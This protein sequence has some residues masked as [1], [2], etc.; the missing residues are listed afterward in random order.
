MKL[1]VGIIFGG[2]SVEHEI[3]VISA[4]QA[5]N[6]LNKEKFDLVP[7]YISKEGKFYTGNELIDLGNYGNLNSLITK[8]EEV[9]FV[10]RNNVTNL[11]PVKKS[12]FNNK[13]IKV[14][15]VIPI[16]HGVNV[17]DGN[18]Q[19]YLHTLKVP[20]AG[21]DVTSAA[22]GQDKVIQKAVLSANDVKTAPWFWLY[23]NDFE[24]NKDVFITKANK[25]GYPLIIKPAKL[26]SSIGIEIVNNDHELETMVKECG[27]YDPKLLI[28]KVITNFKEIN[29]AIMGNSNSYKLSVMEEV[30]K[31]DDILSFN[32]KYLSSNKTKGVKQSTK[33][34]KGMASTTRKVP[35]EVSLDIKKLIEKE[36]IKAF[37]AIGVTGNCRIDFMYDE[38]NNEIYLTE[39]NTIPGSLAFYLWNECDIS[40]DKLLEEMIDIAIEKERIN[41]KVVVSFDT[42]ILQ[43]FA[44]RS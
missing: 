24:S 5:M 33:G 4:N 22:V 28:E 41:D 11:E 43:G 44:K 23:A 42:N 35:A 26:G 40:F 18:L 31:N 8:L 19:G 3:S 13:S 37:K 9:T 21:C 38:K 17:E 14:D 10:R 7:I 16:V 12:I 15:V 1:Q 29:I 32:D 27:K 30:L 25:L 39:V 36:A 2:Q 6:A 20:F 34:S